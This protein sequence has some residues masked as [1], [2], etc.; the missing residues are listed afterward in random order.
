MMQKL[1]DKFVFFDVNGT[2]SE[3]RYKDILYGVRCFDGILNRKEVIKN[4]NNTG[5][6]PIILVKYLS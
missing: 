5:P 1:T 4:F 2:L 6:I 3:Y